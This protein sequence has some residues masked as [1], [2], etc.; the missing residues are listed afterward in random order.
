MGPVGVVV[1][2]KGD[3]Q[4]VMTPWRRVESQ[5]VELVLRA[6]LEGK[7]ETGEVERERKREGRRE[8]RGK[9][10]TEGKLKGEE[11]GGGMKKDSLRETF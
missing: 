2:G 10:A 4:T 8:E 11:R 6:S 7:E 5:G 1:D 3:T 9:E